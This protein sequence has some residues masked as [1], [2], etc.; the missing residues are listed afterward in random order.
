MTAA[1][2]R[3]LVRAGDPLEQA[4]AFSSIWEKKKELVPHVRIWVPSVRHLTDRIG[5]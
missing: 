1:V 3:D 5:P 4:A 2:D